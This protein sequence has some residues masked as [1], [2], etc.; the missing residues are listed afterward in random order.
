VAKPEADKRRERLAAAL[1]ENLK[2]RK[3]HKRNAVTTPDQNACNTRSEPSSE[4]GLARLKSP[5]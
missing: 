1:R 3:K 4:G 2:R 5:R